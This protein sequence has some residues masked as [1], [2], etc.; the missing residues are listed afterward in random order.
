MSIEKAKEHYQGVS[1]KERLNCGQA[2]LKAFQEK[3]SV[4]DELIAEFKAYGAGK[5]PEGY[6]GAFYAAKVILEKNFPGKLGDLENA[7][8]SEAGSTKCKK[9]RELRK[10]SCL[11]CIEK[12]AQALGNVALD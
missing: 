12:A 1:G 11:G 5:A 8:A 7:F 3:F 4:S 9:I 6:C 2:V 10:L